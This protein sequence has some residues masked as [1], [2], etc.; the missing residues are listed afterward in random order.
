MKK[1]VPHNFVIKLILKVFNYYAIYFWLGEVYISEKGSDE[2]GDGTSNMPF[3]TVL[4]VRT[5][6]VY[7]TH[8]IFN[9]WTL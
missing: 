6:M 2:S 1:Y 3:K 8:R 5:M 9:K 7:N 4:Q